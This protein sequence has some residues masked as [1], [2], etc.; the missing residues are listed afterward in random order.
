MNNP[1]TLS[2]PSMDSQSRLEPDA[3]V[4]TQGHPLPCLHLIPPI[5]PLPGDPRVAFLKWQADHVNPLTP[6]ISFVAP[7]MTSEFK[8][9]ASFHLPLPHLPPAGLGASPGQA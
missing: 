9:F 7:Y 8:I 2:W 3:R 5:P 1:L 4:N 6:L